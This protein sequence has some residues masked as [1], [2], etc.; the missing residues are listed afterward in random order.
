M[1]YDLYHSLKYLGYLENQIDKLKDLLRSQEQLILRLLNDLH[2]F[3]EN[4]IW[5]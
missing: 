1:T 5:V 2:I 3:E 4:S